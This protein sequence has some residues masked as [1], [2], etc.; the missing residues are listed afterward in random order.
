MNNVSFYHDKDYNCFF[1]KILMKKE[2]EELRR[3]VLLGRTASGKSAVIKRL[4]GMGYNTLDEMGRT[5]LNFR[6]SMDF[7]DDETKQKQILMYQF[8]LYYEDA[9]EGT[10]FFER[11][12]PCSLAFSKYFLDYVPFE[13]DVSLMRNRYHRVFVLDSLKFEKDDVRVEANE[14][15]AQEIQDLTEETYRNFGYNLIRVPKFSENKNKSIEERV[16]LILGNLD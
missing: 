1:T 3:I 5:I 8:Q 2:K 9:S 7:S 15:E 12:L 10:V 6:K 11:A 16:K 13:I 4:S 14:V